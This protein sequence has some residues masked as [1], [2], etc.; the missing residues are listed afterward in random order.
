MIS[1]LRFLV[2]EIPPALS[3]TYFVKIS[4]RSDAIELQIRSLN[5]SEWHAGSPI[6]LCDAL[7]NCRNSAHCWITLHVSHEQCGSISKLRR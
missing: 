6:L 5:P 7:D 2:S 3:P 1:F 4:D